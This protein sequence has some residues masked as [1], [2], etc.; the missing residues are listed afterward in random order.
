MFVKTHQPKV[1]EIKRAWH[2]IDAKGQ[3]LGRMATQVAT[4]LIGKHKADYSAHLDCGDYVVVVNASK[5]EL[6]GKKPIQKKYYSH[7]GYPGGFKEVSFEKL[8]SQRPEKVI[9]HAVSGMLPDNRLKKNRMK[10]LNVFAKNEHSYK[11]KF[12]GEQNAKD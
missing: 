10:R 12:P 8:F 3:I 5:V 9:E 4:F 6:T 7:S 1:K 11:D 2:L